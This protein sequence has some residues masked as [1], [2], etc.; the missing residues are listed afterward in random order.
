MNECERCGAT[1]HTS[2]DDYG[3]MDYCGQCG[4]N[5]CQSCMAQGCC[6]HMP[7]KSGMADE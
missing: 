7:A 4:T 3:L 1:E 5:L 2:S 6:G